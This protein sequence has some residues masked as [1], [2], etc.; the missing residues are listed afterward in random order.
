MA[1]RVKPLVSTKWLAEALL[2]SEARSKSTLGAEATSGKVVA[3]DASWHMPFYGGKASLKERNEK[4]QIWDDNSGSWRDL[5]VVRSGYLEYVEKRIPHARFF[6]ID[7]VSDQITPLPHMLPAPEDFSLAMQALGITRNDHVVIYD[8]MGIFSSPRV[9]WTFKMFH[10]SRVS[11]LDGGLPKWLEEG[12]PIAR[13]EQKF[14]ESEYPDIGM[15]SSHLMDYITLTNHVKDFQFPGRVTVVDARPPLRFKGLA[16][17]PRPGL[18]KGHIPTSRNIPFG[19][20]IDPTT[21]QLLP[22]EA[23]KKVFDFANVDLS[24]PTV[25]SC[26][27]GVTACT[28]YL[29]ADIL[30]AKDIK[31][32]DGSWAEWGSKK[33]A[34][35]QSDN[36]EF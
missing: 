19:S 36:S 26:G 29:A 18:R 12:L 9:Y 5:P 14:T 11:V 2:A 15:D 17:E 8:S 7:A 25:F 1:S 16:E 6:D 28:L 23:L 22:P 30:G 4:G 13:G 34:P 20:L 31:V 10:H 32:Y 35:I 33:E 27:S 24:K 3:L 21:R